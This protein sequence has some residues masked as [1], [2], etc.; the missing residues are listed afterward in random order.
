MAAANE[1][2]DNRAMAHEKAMMSDGTDYYCKYNIYID[3]YTNNIKVP[4]YIYI[5]NFIL[6]ILIDV[7]LC[8]VY[9][10]M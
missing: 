4:H 10:Y 3:L 6:H 9:V 2:S 8:V 7:N 5:I 1:E